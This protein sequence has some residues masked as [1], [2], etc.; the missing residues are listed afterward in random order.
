MKFIT[1]SGARTIHEKNYP[2][3][4][5]AI[6]DAYSAPVYGLICQSVG[7]NHDLAQNLTAAVF[8]K[9]HR[10]MHVF[11]PEQ[12]RLFTWIYLIAKKELATKGYELMQPV[13]C[14]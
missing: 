8:C 4:F 9:V 2:E 5:S 14:V 7:S 1:I 11:D 10:Q 13:Q 6:Y 12:G 3:K